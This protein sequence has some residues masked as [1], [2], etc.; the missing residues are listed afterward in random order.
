MMRRE[1]TL[2]FWPAITANTTS[3]DKMKKIMKFSYQISFM[4]T[5]APKDAKTEF[6]SQLSVVHVF[7]LSLPDGFKYCQFAEGAFD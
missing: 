1:E 6:Y 4:V 3:C 5:M 2:R 7:S